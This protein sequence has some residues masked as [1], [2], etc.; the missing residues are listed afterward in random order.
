M[1]VVD[2]SRLIKTHSF[3]S[4]FNCSLMWF[5]VV[6]HIG[7]PE[8]AQGNE[9]STAE[10]SNETLMRKMRNPVEKFASGSFDKIMNPG[11]QRLEINYRD[12]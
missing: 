1:P 6:E 2:R 12:D 8:D 7:L 4:T 10:D 9:E 5:S 11:N 3:P